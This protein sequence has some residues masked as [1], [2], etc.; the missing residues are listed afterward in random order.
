MG[1]KYKARRRRAGYRAV[2]PQA[3]VPSRRRYY[4]RV[5]GRSAGALVTMPERKY[6]DSLLS[7]ANVAGST[8]WQGTELVPLVKLTL[9]V[10]TQGSGISNRIG[11]KIAVHKIKVRGV[12][13]PTVLSDQADMVNPPSVRL[14]LVQD[15]QTNGSQ[16]QG[17]EIMQAPATA[18][19]A[20]TNTSF[21]SLANFGR[22]RVL[23]DKQYTW[24]HNSSGTDGANTNSIASHIKPFKFT[25]NFRKPVIVHFNS[26]NGGAG[27]GDIGDIV[28]NSFHII[29]N[30]QVGNW[31][32][33]CSYNART[34]FT[35]L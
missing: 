3:I 35:D 25:V 6:Y 28:D 15:K 17:E 8:N 33:T 26:Q 2:N 1:W 16:M 22:F 5:A 13:V 32:V 19:T 4:S 14:L 7:A 31:T 9:C 24:A 30:Q 20:L 23:K 11:R 34:V 27:D 21:Q 29:G 12:L 18:T 10:P